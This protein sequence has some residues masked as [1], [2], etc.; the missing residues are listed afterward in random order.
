MIRKELFKISVIIITL[1][2]MNNLAFCQLKKAN[3]YF[4]KKEYESAIPYYQKV[5][6][7]DTIQQEA[8]QKIAF[9]YQQ[10]KDNRNAAIYFEKAVQLNPQENSNYL[11][12]GQ[13]LKSNGDIEEAK[14]QFEKFIDKNPDSPIGK[15]MVQS[16]NDILLWEK[17]KKLFKVTL[18]QNINSPTAD[19]CPVVYQ[20]GLIFV[21]E[22]G[23]DLVNEAPSGDTEG[24]YL[25][26][27]YAKETSN[28]R[29]VKRFSNQLNSLYHD[30]PATISKDET[31]IYFTRGNKKERG[32]NYVNRL[33]IYSATLIG[34][35]C[36]DITPFQYNSNEYSLIHPSISE[37]QQKIFFASDMPG[38]FGGMDLY[39]CH[40]SG[41]EWEKP[42]NLGKDIN[43]S[44]NEVFPTYNNGILYFSSN[45]HSGYGNLD[46]YAA[47]EAENWKIAVNLRAPI[48]SSEDDFGIFM[49]NNGNGY[50]SSNRSGG[51]GSDDIYRFERQELV[52]TTSIYGLLEYQLLKA[53]G[54][55]INL[56]DEEGNIIGTIKTDAT[57]R[58]Q[59]DKLTLDKNYMLEI[60]ETE[61]K[62]IL[63]DSKLYITNSK[64][65]KV[66][67][68]NRTAN[69]KFAFETLPY[70]HYDTL[71]LIEEE[72][73]EESLFTI[74]LF[75]QVYETL[76]GDYSKSMEIW[77]VDDDG[78]I[79]GKTTTDK[80]GKFVFD[81]L[82]PD[83]QYLFMLPENDEGLKMI[84][85]NEEGEVLE[86]ATL[87][88][89]GRYRYT[90]LNMSES[91]IALLN[92][93]DE[94]IEISE[95]ENFTLQKILYEY[96]SSEINEVAAKELDKLI[97]ILNKNKNIGAELKSHTDSKG[98]NEFNM[99]LSQERAN[100]ALEYIV[101]NG[102]ISRSK[103]KAIGYGETQPV[104][105]NN[106]PNGKDNPEGRRK[107][108][109]TEV[110]LIKLNN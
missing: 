99:K 82:T 59:F 58:F 88:A 35:R 42:I 60:D 65:E 3:N 97:V 78:N 30:G 41:E 19:F 39:V 26:I 79:I 6:N 51:V 73:T 29:K 93:E 62:S 105:P 102:N 91:V 45:G 22:R 50:F 101:S 4:N 46:I 40:K 27:F 66:L 80:N 15:T 61:D 69:G 103:I 37:D 11:Y 43:T 53:S 94:I 24:P 34:D 104:S 47:N 83:K 1:L 84:I 77:V 87:L 38:G 17:E 95:N 108:R 109:R 23:V 44:G 86:A 81:K 68:M 49:E 72:D 75:G 52:A 48:N 13:A 33:K 76:P 9:S 54:A 32:K 100:K 20:D 71:E 31:S 98:G 92:E 14:I 55:S 96:R 67:L 90:R 5:L 107:N 7:K 18:L 74:Q 110:T 25:S 106:L 56:L 16:C 12:Y 10:L 57:G 89:N 70:E 63:K 36:K 21:S 8:I 28:Y 64:G 2:D 85:V